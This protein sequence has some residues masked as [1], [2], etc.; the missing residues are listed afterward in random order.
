MFDYYGFILFNTYTSIY[1]SIFQTVSCDPPRSHD[2]VFC[3]SHVDAT[4]K[5]QGI[6][7]CRTAADAD[8]VGSRW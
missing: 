3:G 7:Q 1:N 2:P 5:P 4:Q 8:E 6:L